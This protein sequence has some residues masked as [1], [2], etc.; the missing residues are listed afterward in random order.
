GGSNSSSNK[1]CGNLDGFNHQSTVLGNTDEG[2]ANSVTFSLAKPLSDGW[3]G[4]ISYTYTD[5]EEVGSDA[6][7]QAWSSYQYVSRVNPNQEI[8]T[9]ASRAIQNSIKAS[10]GWEHAFFGDYKTSVTAYYT[11]RDGLPYTWLIDGDMHGDNIYQ[12]PAYIPLV[13]DPN[14]NYI[15]A[16]GNAATAEQITAFNEYISGNPYL[17]AHRGEI[18]GRNA[19]RLPWVNQLDLGFQQE[20]PGFFKGHKSIIRLDIYNFLNMLNKDW[21]LTEQIGG[22]DTRYLARLGCT[23]SRDCDVVVNP[24]TADGGYAYN[25]GTEDRPSSQDPSVYD[26]DSRNPSRLVSRWS[27]M[28]TL[29]YQ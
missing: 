25:L 26:A 14:V 28:L 21:G 8:A 7:S 17:Q 2:Y 18:A 15:D 16:R 9:P 20:L 4:N 3:Y 1:N 19:T 6:S 22:F 24:T 23:S 27:A 12:D 5:A 29:R 13:N 11:G 10:L